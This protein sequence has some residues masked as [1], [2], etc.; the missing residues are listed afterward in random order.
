MNT[1]MR[2]PRYNYAAQFDADIEAICARVRSILLRGD[3]D[4]SPENAAFEE[5][6]ALFNG[7]RYARTVGCGTDA[8][9]LTLRALRIGAGD[10]VIVQAN[11]FY[12]TAAAIALAGA[13][14]VLAD[15]DDETYLID[16]QSV[17]AALSPRTRAVIPVHLYGKPTPMQELSELSA[18]HGFFIIEDAAQA[19]GAKIHGRNVGTF[20][21]AG[22]FS[23]HASKNLSAAG[24][25]GCVITDSLD[26]AQAIR[27]HRTHGQLVQHEHLVL[28]TNSKL[29]AIQATILH[30]KLSK[31]PQWN[32]LRREKARRYHDL[33][34]DLPLGFQREDSLEEHVYHLFTIRTRERDSLLAHLRDQGIDAVVRYPCPIH[35]Q[36]A[37][38]AYDW[39]RGQFPV[40]EQ[41]AEQLL[42]LPIRPD[43]SDAEQEYVAAHVRSYF[44]VHAS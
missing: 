21:I 28:G 32:R 6:F 26:L 33:L 18:R 4:Q 8:L 9:V 20:G 17:R 43:I 30:S 15:A 10:E 5:A 3:Y 41:L 23:F 1:N 2:V 29:D 12:A 34:R 13:T 7:T 24:D 35:L 25:G 19:H 36:P 14:P 44:G 38:A 11:T 16:M 27:A 42:C 22:C 40:A 37:F 31:L 39:R